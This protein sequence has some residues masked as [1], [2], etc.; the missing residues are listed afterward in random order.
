MAHTAETYSQ[1][2]YFWFLK[3]FN[4][5]VI[6]PVDDLLYF[7][8][9]SHG[10]A[11]AIIITQQDKQINAEKDW[12]RE[13]HD[14]CPFSSCQK[15][16]HYKELWE[17]VFFQSDSSGCA[18]SDPVQ[19]IT[20]VKTW[21]QPYTTWKMVETVY[22]LYGIKKKQMREKNQDRKAKHSE[23]HRTDMREQNRCF[24]STTTCS[25]VIYIYI[26]I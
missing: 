6:F 19:S 14:G 4:I 3:L 10:A 5:I 25:T 13:K 2:I 20:S 23:L 17:I 26:F 18:T 1:T 21:A 11:A 15:G 7:Y 8:Y 24:Y 16:F 22:S 9:N 12:K